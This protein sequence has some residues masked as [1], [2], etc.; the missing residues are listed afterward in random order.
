MTLPVPIGSE[1]ERSLVDALIKVIEDY[2]L[3]HRR[4][5]G[6]YDLPEGLVLEMHP[7]VRYMI[8]QNW[9][10]GYSAFASG[11]ESPFPAEIPVR[12]NPDLPDGTWR[13]AV[14]TVEV[15]SG[16]RMRPPGPRA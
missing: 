2:V 4:P 15:I 7:R 11:R 6:G 10:P 8:Q 1:D 16:G 3:E 5:G 13:L 12:I 9:A 14:V